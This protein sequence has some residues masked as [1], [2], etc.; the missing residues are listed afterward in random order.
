MSQTDRK[1]G[2]PLEKIGLAAV[3]DTLS[4]A[5]FGRR[6][7]RRRAL[8]SR[9]HLDLFEHDLG[10][11]RRR[12]IGRDANKPSLAFIPDGPA[13]I[14][15]YDALIEA[16]QDEFNILIMEMP[17]FG[18][19]FA[20]KKSALGFEQSAQMLAAA[21]AD[22]N[23]PRLTLIGPC[24][25]A[26]YA[27]RVAE[28]APD[29]VQALIL[30]QSGDFTA[31]AEWSKILDPAGVLAKPYVGQI[32]FRLKR[33]SATV[34]WWLPF[35]SGPKTPLEDLQREARKTQAQG[36]CYALA[37]QMQVLTDLEPKP[38]L[39]PSQPTAVLWGLADKSHKRTNKRSTLSIVPEAKY[40]EE[41]D[42]AHFPDLENPELIAKLAL[43]L[44]GQDFDPEPVA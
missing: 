26:L 10:F 21:L 20:K 6:G 18:F 7:L 4:F 35:C 43:E 40:L 32:A 12:L 42:L 5:S 37:S 13:T 9:S 44:L 34:D 22:A 1:R 41:A 17:G 11:I 29:H 14:E 30:A 39:A 8:A 23:L 25:Q 16:L 33:T 27:A 3:L 19:S 24:I 38:R 28:I 36:C 15:S 2:L 31:E